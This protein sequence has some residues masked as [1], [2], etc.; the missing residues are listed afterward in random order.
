MSFGFRSISRS[1]RRHARRSVRRATRGARKISPVSQIKNIAKNQIKL[2]RPDQIA[3][4]TLKNTTS[5]LKDIGN[6]LPT[7]AVDKAIKNTTKTISDKALDTVDKGLDEVG[8]KKPLSDLWKS[9]AKPLV[10]FT[11]K[12]VKYIKTKYKSIPYATEV[13]KVAQIHPVVAKYVSDI[14]DVDKLLDLL[15]KSDFKGASALLSNRG[16][17]LAIGKILPSYQKVKLAQAM[18]GKADAVVKKL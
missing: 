14:N 17:Q 9:T 6:A 1:I 12:Q 16:A 13:M 4:T 2:T 5:G 18:I 7:G 10:Q 3:N 11:N 15:S 8:L